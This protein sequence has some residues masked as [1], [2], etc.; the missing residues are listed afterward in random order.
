MLG[1]RVEKKQGSRVQEVIGFI[2]LLGF[3]GF[4]G[5][6][7]LVFGVCFSFD[8]GRWMFDVRRSCLVKRVQG[9]KDSRVRGFKKL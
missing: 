6:A 5:F 4:I 2:E 3:I 1:V 9:S 8:V 7:G